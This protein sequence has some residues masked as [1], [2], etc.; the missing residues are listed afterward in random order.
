MTNRDP[1]YAKPRSRGEALRAYLSSREFQV[2]YAVRLL[3]GMGILAA[4]VYFVVKGR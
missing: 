4:I 2:S 3:I 1:H